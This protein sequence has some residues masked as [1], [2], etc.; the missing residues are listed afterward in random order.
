MGIPDQG[1]AVKDASG[2]TKELAVE[3]LEGS[4]YLVP[5]HY[6]LGDVL[7]TSSISNP[8]AVTGTVFAT[9]F[10]EVQQVTASLL[11]SLGVTGTVAVDNFPTTQTVT[12]SVENPVPYIGA[13][14]ISVNS[15]S[16]TT[17][18]WDGTSDG[19]FKVADRDYARKELIIHNSGPGFLY[20]KLSPDEE[21]ANN[22]HGF[23]NSLVKDQ[24]PLNYNFV[25][26]PSGTYTTSDASRVLYH[27]GFFVS[28][29]TPLTGTV[30]STS[31]S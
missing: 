21:D 15:L 25:V 20:I 24:V 9:G 11:N 27:G 7:V 3:L 5:Y 18:D 17:V 10:P 30:Q 31:I 12:A 22:R 16:V 14:G 26:Y 8:V 1:L 23:T 6:V 2:V 29:S 19:S 28:S 4:G 13:Y